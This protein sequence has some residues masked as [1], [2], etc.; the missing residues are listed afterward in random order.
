MRA[1]A[2]GAVLYAL[3]RE[4]EVPAA[5]IAQEIERTVAEKAVEVVRIR[6]FV[7]RK[8]LALPVLKVLEILGLYNC[9]AA[10][11]GL[12]FCAASCLLFSVAHGVPSFVVCCLFYYI[13][14]TRFYQ[15]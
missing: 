5:F 13:A 7:A 15:Y 12:D 1:D 14:C 8:I 6:A 3:L 9:P 10:C 11:F 4:G 2:P